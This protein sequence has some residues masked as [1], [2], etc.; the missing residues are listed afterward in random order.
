MSKSKL[1]VLPEL[2]KADVVSFEKIY[3]DYH[4]RL[5]RFLKN[6]TQK[7]SDSEEIA[8]DAFIKVFRHFKEFD[9]TKS[10]FETWF[11]TIVNNT[12][13]DFYRTTNK[14][15]KAKGEK[16]GFSYDAVNDEDHAVF[17]VPFKG[18]KTDSLYDTN[19]VQSSIESALNG[20]K[21]M[22]KNLAVD[23]FVNE[24]EYSEL[25]EKY[26]L[27]LGTVKGSINRIR[28]KLQGVLN[29]EYNLVCQ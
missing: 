23:Y 7:L 2:S 16:S 28:T 5:V 21:P 3:N 26:E 20:L 8:N 6:K 13:I 22:Y 17:Q 25:V 29:P 18:D 4:N 12:L 11:F 1:I 19:N 15:V 10:S 14:T 24:F 27:P 9:E